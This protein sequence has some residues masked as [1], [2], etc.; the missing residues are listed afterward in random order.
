[1]AALLRGSH[2]RRIRCDKAV[3]LLCDMQERFRS[4]IFNFDTVAYKCSLLK[5]AFQ[6]LDIPTIITEQNP[7]ALGQTIS[8][9]RR[10]EDDLLFE[11]KSFSMLTTEVKGALL[12]SYSKRKDVI[13]CGI[14]GHVCVLQ[15]ALELMS[16]PFFATEHRLHVVCDAV[17]SS[18]YRNKFTA[19]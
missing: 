18:R 10:S 17:S 6:L 12:N 2:W 9:I 11:K 16:D 13:L 4:V 14:E 15:T 3:F 1:M 5:N 8:E 19:L 7:K